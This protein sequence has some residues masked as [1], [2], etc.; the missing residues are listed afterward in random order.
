MQTLKTSLSANKLTT[1]VLE[2]LFGEAGLAYDLKEGTVTGIVERIIY[3]NADLIAGVH[4]GL[5]DEIGD[6]WQE[7][8]STCGHFWGRRV[9]TSIEKYLQV[10]VH[11]GLEQLL[12]TEYLS[13][14]EQYFACHGWGKA[15]IHLEDAKQHGIVRVS[16]HNSIF[17]VALKHVEGPVDQMVAGM[18]RGMFERVA[19]RPLDCLQVAWEHNGGDAAVSEFLVSAPKR[20]EVLKALVTHSIGVDNAIAQL[21]AA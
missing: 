18:L 15:K 16:L 21:R 19:S 14:V 6:A 17:A 9:A 20:I 3:I 4:Q 7:V 11:V 10:T 2:Q 1:Q 8:L 5:I 13:L 12:V